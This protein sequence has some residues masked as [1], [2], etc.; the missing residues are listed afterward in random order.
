MSPTTS[1]TSVSSRSSPNI[2]HEARQ[3]EG[4][5][6]AVCGDNALCKHYGVGTCE[7]CKCFFKVLKFKRIHTY[8]KIIYNF[9]HQ[10][11]QCFYLC[12]FFMFL[13]RSVQ[14]NKQTKYMCLADKNC[15]VDKRRH[16]RCQFCRF[17]KCL[18]VGMVKEGNYCE[19]QTQIIKNSCKVIDIPLARQTS[20]LLRYLHPRMTSWG[21]GG[22]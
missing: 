3:R 16:I 10:I 15:P 18:S 2:G 13:Q 22:W 5:L 14:K 11:N 17:Q 4:M 1:P 20:F 8:L 12:T 9:I 7:G 21:W 6:C 19:T